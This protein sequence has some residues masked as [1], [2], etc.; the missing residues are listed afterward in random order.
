MGRVIL[1]FFFT[2]TFSCRKSEIR[3][4]IVEADEVSGA[5]LSPTFQLLF[6]G[7]H[8][9]FFTVPPLAAHLPAPA[10]RPRPFPVLF[11]EERRG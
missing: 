9:Y 10:P 3:G 8:P 7:F 1:K 4:K 11:G 5:V 6:P 2:V